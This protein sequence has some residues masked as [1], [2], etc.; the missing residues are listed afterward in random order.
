MSYNLSLQK[1]SAQYR[2]KKALKFATVNIRRKNIA[3]KV[4]GKLLKAK[5]SG[6]NVATNFSC[7][8]F[9]KR[10]R[11]KIFPNESCFSF[12]NTRIYSIF[13]SVTF[14]NLFFIV[15]TT[16]FSYNLHCSKSSSIAIMVVV[17]KQVIGDA[18]ISTP[19]EDVDTTEDFETPKT[20]GVVIVPARKKK[21]LTTK[22]KLAK[23]AAPKSDKSESKH[24]HYVEMVEQA[25]KELKT[26]KGSTK[27]AIKKYIVNTYDIPEGGQVCFYRDKG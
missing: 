15:S 17:R 19:V 27:Q 24:P 21:V 11:L 13:L 10:G 6:K 1:C 5:S 2:G 8:K 18:V 26:R 12:F 7:Q 16:H 9:A 23:K 20:T 3:E 25:V 4:C 22:P 14:T